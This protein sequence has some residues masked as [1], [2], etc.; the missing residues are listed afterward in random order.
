MKH[1]YALHIPRYRALFKKLMGCLYHERKHKV[2]KRFLDDTRNTY[3]AFDA[4]IMRETTCNHMMQLTNDDKNLFGLKVGLQKPRP[5]TGQLLQWCVNMFGA[6]LQYVTSKSCW[7][8]NGSIATVGDMVSVDHDGVIVFGEVRFFVEV[9]DVEDSCFLP[10]PRCM[11]LGTEVR[12]THNQHG[13]GWLVPHR[14]RGK[15]IALELGFFD[16]LMLAHVARP[17]RSHP[18]SSHLE[19]HVCD[20]A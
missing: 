1:H 14:R 12:T 17:Q 8:R 3:C 13:P 15:G 4:S 6:G 11:P 9:A 19:E 2:A 10:S 16:H 18:D 20:C 7:Y 5:C